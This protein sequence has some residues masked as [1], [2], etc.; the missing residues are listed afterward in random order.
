[1]TTHTL[2]DGPAGTAPDSPA[3]ALANRSPLE[4]LAQLRF[5]GF[6]GVRQLADQAAAWLREN[7]PGQPVA[8]EPRGCPTP[9][10]CSCVVPTTPNPNA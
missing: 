10:A 8:I 6:L 4:R 2:Y 7:P 9:G 5:Q 3:E 1:M